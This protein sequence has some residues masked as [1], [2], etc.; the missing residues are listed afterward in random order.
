MMIPPDGVKRKLNGVV[1][2]VPPDKC[3]E[4]LNG[5]VNDEEWDKS[6][7][8]NVADSDDGHILVKWGVIIKCYVGSKVSNVQY[9][10]TTIKHKRVFRNLSSNDHERVRWPMGTNDIFV[11]KLHRQ[12]NTL[13]IRW[14]KS[15]C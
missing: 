14:H 2:S 7:N 8:R 10:P 3:C 12:P 15:K 9:D 13:P 1:D 6:D 11:Y 4:V 5:G